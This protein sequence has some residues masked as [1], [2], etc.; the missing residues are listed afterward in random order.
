M[1]YD[2]AAILKYCKNRILHERQI[3]QGD[4]FHSPHNTIPKLENCDT[5]I[6]PST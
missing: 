5:V 6:M 1:E 3:T 4:K 2:Y